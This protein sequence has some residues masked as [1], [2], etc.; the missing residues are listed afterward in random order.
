METK[1]SNPS[2]ELIEIP[3]GYL[4]IMGYVDESEVNG[5]GSRAVI[6]VQG[7]PR[8]CPGCFNPESW[9]FKI[10]Q[11]IA[12]DTLVEKILSKP[13]N[14]GVT[15]S[16]GE[17]FWQAT[18]LASLAHKVKAAGL[19][20]MSFTGFTLNQLQSESAPPDSLTLLEQLDILIDGPF[21]ESLAINSP[22]SP[23]SS[24]NQRVR[25]LN[26]AFADQITWASDQI[27][28]HV[29]K[30]GSRIVTGYQGGLK[31]T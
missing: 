25:V 14:T 3:P 1:P 29:L 2:P 30:D 4:N 15:F 31:L 28:I 26:P 8:E 18:A 5:P 17:P 20:V 6:W 13:Q 16:G 19:N 27:E 23:V 22:D 24:S 9:P 7:C 11:L 12:V 21:V 10:N